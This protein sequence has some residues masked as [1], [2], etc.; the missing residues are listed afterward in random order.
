MGETVENTSVTKTDN[1][2][3]FA[4][5]A[6]EE[7]IP[8]IDLRSYFIKPDQFEGIEVLD[9][10]C[11]KVEG[12]PNFRQVAGFPVFGTGQPTE[13]GMVKILNHIRK[14]KENE[15]IIWF[16][17]RQEPIV[18]VNGSPYAPRAPSHPHANIITDVDVEQTNSV[19]MHLANV[20]KKRVD[21]E[22]KTIKIH[23][24]KEFAEN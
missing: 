7:D 12:A 19:C 17:M 16:S 24:D 11:E 23:V 5:V 22:D 13:E 1:E 3:E 14:E 6:P 10:K 4:E 15:K 20:L 9:E 8:F 21:K 18:Y 2:E